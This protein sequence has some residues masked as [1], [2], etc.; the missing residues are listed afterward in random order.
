L[1]MIKSL[2]AAFFTVLGL[3]VLAG[4]ALNVLQY[5]SNPIAL[6]FTSLEDHGGR[7]GAIFIATGVILAML[8]SR[9]K[10]K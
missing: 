3:T 5:R 8:P 10:E 9:K 7:M 6:F 4:A 2:L 1:N